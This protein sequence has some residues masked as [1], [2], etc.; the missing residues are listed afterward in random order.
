MAPSNK[1]KVR[2][3]QYIND[4]YLSDIISYSMPEKRH[5]VLQSEI[6]IQESVRSLEDVVNQVHETFSEMLLRTIDEKGLVDSEVYKKAHVDRKLFSKIRNDREYRPSKSTVVAFAL[7]LEL[8]LDE[9]QDLLLRAGFALSPSNKSD[10]I[11]QFFITEGIHDLLQ[12]NEALYAFH[13]PI[14][15][16]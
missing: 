14:L 1:M 13:Q 5:N 11:I 2:I 4:H 6:I 7:A 3:Q 9:T 12:V 15:G 10:V 16:E 8:D